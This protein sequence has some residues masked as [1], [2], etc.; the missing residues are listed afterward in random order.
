GRH[1][2]GP[3]LQLALLVFLFG[4]SILIAMVITYFY[5]RKKSGEAR[6][7][8]A[9]LEKGD[10]RARFEIKRLDEIGSLMVD[11]N[12]MASEIERLVHRIQETE[13]A[14]KILL[15]ELS[16]DLRTPL[17]SLNTSVDTLNDHWEEMP[18]EEQQ[19]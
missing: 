18:R 4:V 9:K 2:E 5:L 17:T 19:E 15:E 14:R 6:V 16:H 7:V 3:W 11:F 10:L 1:R 8:L 13:T 12:R